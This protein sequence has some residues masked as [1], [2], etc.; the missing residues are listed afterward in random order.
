[1]YEVEKENKCC[2]DVVEIPPLPPQWTL[3][4]NFI[5]FQAREADSR[6]QLVQGD[7]IRLHWERY[8]SPN[9]MEHYESPSHAEHHVE[10]YKSPNNM[11]RYKSPN[12][13]KGRYES[14]NNNKERY[15]PT[16][17]NNNMERYISQNSLE[18]YPQIAERFETR[19]TTL[20][21]PRAGMEIYEL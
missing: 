6:D 15:K 11:E 12:N 10:R 5:F 16:I 14:P 3:D 7:H 8:E 17:N 1:M 4:F 2:V 19:S 13:N 9:S 18:R 21:P 20:G